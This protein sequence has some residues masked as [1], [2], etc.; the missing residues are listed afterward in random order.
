[1]LIENGLYL[2]YGFAPFHFQGK[3][4]IQWKSFIKTQKEDRD[5]KTIINQFVKKSGSHKIIEFP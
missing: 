5:V 2:G 4:P 3:I 1:M